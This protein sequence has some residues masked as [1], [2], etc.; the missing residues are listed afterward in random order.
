RGQRDREGLV[1][2]EVDVG[3]HVHGVARPGPEHPEVVH[4]RVVVEDERVRAGVEVRHRGAARVLE[5]DHEGVVQ[6]DVAGQ[7]RIVSAARRRQQQSGDE[8]R[9]EHEAAHEPSSS[10]TSTSTSI[11]GS[12]GSAKA[13]SSNASGRIPSTYR[14]GRRG[15]P[16][17]IRYEPNST[18]SPSTTASTRFIAGEPMNAATKRFA[19]DRYRFCGESTCWIRPSRITAT[20]WPRVIAST[21]SCV[22]YTVVTPSRRWSCE[23][24]ARMPTRSLA[25]RFESGS[26]SRN[27]CG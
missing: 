19:G 21:W 8:R 18:R 5:R 26:S 25:S 13:A 22:T 6:P 16:S 9:Y 4:G 11:V 15:A 10:T 3:R 12:A 23:R 14:P 24:D 17:G 1:A 7:D 20:R 2:D 27:A